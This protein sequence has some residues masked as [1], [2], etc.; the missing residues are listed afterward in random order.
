MLL[1][2]LSAGAAASELSGDSISDDEQDEAAQATP[3][4]PGPALEVPLQDVTLTGIGVN[5]LY[6]LVISANSDLMKA[7][8]AAHGITEMSVGPWRAGAGCLRVRDV[9]YTKKLNIPLP[10]APEKCHVWEEHRLIMKEPGGWVVLINCKNDAPKSDCFEAQVQ[11]CG[12]YINGNTSKLRV[13]M[14]VRHF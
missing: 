2:S 14:Q 5:R 4:Q 10:L 7:H 8:N 11:M 9:S 12:V 6:A 1:C 3:I 13:S